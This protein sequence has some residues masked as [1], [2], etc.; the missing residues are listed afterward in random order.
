M[1]STGGVGLNAEGNL[2]FNGSTLTVTGTITETSAKRFKENIISIEDSL[3]KVLQ[4]NPIEF[5]WIK[6]N[7]RDVGLIAEEV[8]K[9]LPLLV[10]KENGEIYGIHYSRLTAILIGAIQEL[11][12]RVEKLEN[13]Q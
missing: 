12:K 11:T 5:D 6:D 2:T 4:L 3:S 1:T 8:D 9:V 10:Q 7:K 13:K